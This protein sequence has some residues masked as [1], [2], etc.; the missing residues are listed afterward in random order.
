MSSAPG[1]DVRGAALR[2]R[3]REGG[4]GRSRRVYFESSPY[5]LPH[6]RQNSE[7]VFAHPRN[8]RRRG[9][10]IAVEDFLVALN[11]AGISVRR[12]VVPG[13]SQFLG[14]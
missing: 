2:F 8:H 5:Q 3:L 9:G 6:S 11:Q 12:I 1:T 13:A 10:L 14:F 7:T 4:C